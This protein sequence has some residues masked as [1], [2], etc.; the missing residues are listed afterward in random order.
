MLY[1]LSLL[2]LGQPCGDV[3]GHRVQPLYL[4]TDVNRIDEV[5]PALIRM[6]ENL[7]AGFRG[8]RRVRFVR[9]ARCDI[10]IEAIKVPE[11]R[12]VAEEWAALPPAPGPRNYVF[13]I[14]WPESSL[15]SFGSARSD[16]QPGDDNLNNAD[17][18][19]SRLYLGC[20]DR[21]TLVHEFLHSLGAVQPGAPRAFSRFHCFGVADVMCSA[22]YADVDLAGEMY[23]NPSPAPGSYLATHWNIAN[24]RFLYSTEPPPPFRIFIP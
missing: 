1:L 11:P 10:V 21:N 19:W 4:Y 8:Y 6:L 13:F 12:S 5:R 17:G 23:Y 15:C 16:S 14:D 2:L 7:D 18:Q 24:S 3:S 9:D 22:A 20:W